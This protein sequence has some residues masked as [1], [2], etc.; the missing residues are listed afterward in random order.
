[1]NYNSPMCVRTTRRLPWLPVLLCAAALAQPKS[2]EWRSMFD[3]KTLQGWRET[4]FTQHGKARVEDGKI[5]LTPGAPM[6]GVTWSGDFPKS[7]YEVRFEAARIDGNDFFAS[8]T[9]PVGDSFC[10]LVTGGWGGDIVGLSSLDG[11]DA[12]DNETRT[13]FEFEK[14]RWY[15]FRLQ[16]TAARIV[17]WIDDRQIVNVEIG[18][19]KVGLR[20]GEIQLS[21]PF[22]FASYGTT[23][24]LRKIEYRRVR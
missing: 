9:F 23:G 13:Y 17:G 8:L 20:Y 21:A 1:M 6:T 15:A 4:A 12:S 19:R 14:G 24:A 16:V 3:G 22:G 11:W 2:G 18:G 7:D 5:L 10:T